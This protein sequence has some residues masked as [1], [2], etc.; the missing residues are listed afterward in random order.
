MDTSRIK[1]KIGIHEFE[2]EGPADIVKEQLDAFKE[3]ISSNPVSTALSPSD[4]VGQA[5]NNERDSIG[6]PHVNLEKVMHVNG[7]IVSLTAIP[8][9]TEDAALLIMLGHKDLRNNISVT[10]QEIGDGLAQSG[11]P[12][13]RV[14]R[15]MESAISEASVLRSGVKRGTRYRLTN[16]GLAKALGLAR[17]LMANLP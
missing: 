16:Q 2:A 6:I 13:P 3:L 12:V 10:G 7:R 14:D 11:R 5:I 1:M 9:S 8:T 15:I 17:D 4:Q